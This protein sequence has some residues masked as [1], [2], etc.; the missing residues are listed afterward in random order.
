MD[1]SFFWLARNKFAIFASDDKRIIYTEG[2]TGS[3]L[4]KDDK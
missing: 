2:K 4:V 3:K 1:K